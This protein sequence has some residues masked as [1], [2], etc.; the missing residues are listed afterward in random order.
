MSYSGMKQYLAHQIND[1]FFNSALEIESGIF[2]T[3]KPDRHNA[4]GWYYHDDNID[5][6]VIIKVLNQHRTF[7]DIKET[8][9]HELIH[10][11]QDSI[12][13]C[14]KMSHNG[15]TFRYWKA[16]ACRMYGIPYNR[17]F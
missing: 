17:Y 11:W 8:L 6:P 7:K 14:N 16:K 13:E 12:A 2:K 1:E 9:V 10:Y 3:K 15:K 5:A 4:R